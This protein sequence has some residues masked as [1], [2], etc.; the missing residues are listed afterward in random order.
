MKEHISVML[1]ETLAAI[2][3]DKSDICV[4]DATLGLGGHSAAILERYECAFVYGF[5]RDAAAREIASLRL[6]PFAPRFEIIADNFRNISDLALRSDFHG[7]DFVLFDLGVSN[8]QLTEGER[9]FSFQI[10]GPLDMRMESGEEAIGVNAADILANADVSRLTKIFRDYGEERN[11]FQ[12][13]KGIVRYR[14]YGG[15]L[16]TTGELVALVRKILPEPLQRKMGGHPARK[17]FQ[18]LRIA[19]NDEINALDEALDGALKILKP[20]GKIVVISYHS[21]EE[22]MTKL[23]FRRWRDEKKGEITPKKPILPTE[24]EVAENY[25]ARSAKMMIFR[26]YECEENSGI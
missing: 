3:D 18:A 2:D 21:L 10:N 13:A 6:A 24:D 4:A 8:M 12:I 16:N 17:I 1:K 26:K 25:K 22:K 5:D 20:K 11:A 9:G 15:T 14:E 7:A 23:H 19:V